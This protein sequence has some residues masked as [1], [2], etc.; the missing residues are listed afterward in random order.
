MTPEFLAITGVGATTARRWL[1]MLMVAAVITAGACSD[2]ST[3]TA[4]TAPSPPL[5]A[6][7]MTVGANPWGAT[8]FI[9]QSS[10]AAVG[11]GALVPDS[12]TRHG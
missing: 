12:F 8:G 5:F 1:M 2:D 11:F 7:D 9:S 6:A 3:P 4:P 10:D